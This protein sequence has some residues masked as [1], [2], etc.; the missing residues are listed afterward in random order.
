MVGIPD[1]PKAACEK[2]VFVVTFPKIR[3]DNNK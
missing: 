2:K 3:N 1:P